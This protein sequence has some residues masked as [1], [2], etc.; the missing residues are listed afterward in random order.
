MKIVHITSIYDVIR[1]DSGAR[2]LMIYL[3]AKKQL[4]EGHE[5]LIVANQ[6][7]KLDT[8]KI[9]S[10]SRMLKLRYNRVINWLLRRLVESHQH[11]EALKKFQSD[12]DIVHSHI[13][14]EGTY[15]SSVFKVPI[16]VTNHGTPNVNKCSF[17]L[18]KF[19]SII[20]KAK[21]VAISYRNYIINRMIYGHNVIGYVYNGLDIAKIPF[22]AKPN[23]SH[24]IELCFAGRII[25]IKGVHV[26]IKVADILHREGNDVLLKIHGIPYPGYYKYLHRILSMAKQRRYVY[27]KLNLPKNK[28]Y[29]SLG[30]CDALL[31]PSL[32][33]EPFGYIIIETMATGT[34]VIAFPV[35]A[36]PEIICDEVNGFLVHNIKG[37][38]NA[39]MSIYKINRHRVREYVH[40]KFNVESMYKNYLN[41]YKKVLEDE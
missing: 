21:I 18:S 28:L 31:F 33:D 7:S 16:I 19:L 14:E 23:K 38:V 5:V 24:D 11:F 27:V 20:N 30:N 17:I 3:L 32:F 29:E 10:F 37:M 15:L 35:G 25:P 2:A 8:C 22:T 34:P 39:V 13:T 6:L 40:K 1:E 4:E 26:A 9:L 36:V 41:I 12:V